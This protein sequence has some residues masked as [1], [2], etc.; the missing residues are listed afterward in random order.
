MEA[1]SRPLAS[2]RVARH[3]GAQAADMGE[4]G[5]GALAVRLPA[6]DAA[7]AGHADGDRAVKS[8][9]ERWRRRAARDD[10]VGGRVEVVGELDLD[11]RAQ[12]VGRHADGRADDAASDRRVKAA[13]L[14]VLGLQALR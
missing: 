7:A 6:V 13:R 10:L 11:H 5:L 1:I 4:H 8:P 14:A 9:A 3:D 2:Y 12:A